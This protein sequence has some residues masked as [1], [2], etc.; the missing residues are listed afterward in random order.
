MASRI[1]PEKKYRLF[2]GSLGTEWE[3]LNQVLKM[4][5]TKLR[6]LEENI[7]IV[8]LQMQTA[9]GRPSDAL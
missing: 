3:A 1:V 4:Q 5:E 8:K 2:D 6:Q 9:E 7:E